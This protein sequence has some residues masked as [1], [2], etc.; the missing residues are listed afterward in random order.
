MRR[1]P[2]TTDIPPPSW[3]MR[4]ALSMALIAAA[5]AFLFLLLIGVAT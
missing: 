3:W 5:M 4:E 1:K 2:M